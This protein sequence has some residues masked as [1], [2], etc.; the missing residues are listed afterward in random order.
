[1]ENEMRT[2]LLIPVGTLLALL[3]MGC[4]AG[5]GSG[6]QDLQPAASS[7]P[8][9]DLQHLPALSE[10]DA[11][12][13]AQRE[14]SVL[15]PGWFSFF[16]EDYTAGSNSAVN[17]AGVT[18]FSS[19]GGSAW[20]MYRIGGF[21]SDFSPTSLH[22]HID[23]GMSQPYYLLVA[24][25]RLGRW[26][27]TGPFTGDVNIELPGTETGESHPFDY[28]SP[29]G[30]FYCSVLVDGGASGDMKLE[31]LELGIHGGVGAPRPPRNLQVSTYSVPA[32][33]ETGSVPSW[34][35]SPDYDQ[36]D[37]A[38]YIVE[39]TDFFDSGYMEIG[40]AGPLET[41]IVI[42]GVRRTTGYRVAAHDVSGNRS[43]W[44]YT[45][46]DSSVI[47]LGD[48]IMQVRL[49][50]PRGPL[51]GPV[52]VSFD[53]S[54]SYSPDGTPIAEYKLTFDN[55]TL[56]YSGAD[57][58]VTRTLQPGCYLITATVSDSSGPGGVS[59]STRRKLIVYPRWEAA[60]I[61]V[62]EADT[63]L[64]LDRFMM[65]NGGIDPLSGEET[66]ISY[67]ATLPGIAIR[68][69]SSGS[70]TLVPLP[71]TD[72]V[73]SQF[74]DP[75]YFDGNVYFG[76]NY[77]A[78]PSH[79]VSVQQSEASHIRMSISDTWA[80]PIATDDSLFLISGNPA[81]LRIIDLLNPLI[82]V[83]LVPPP[84]SN[85]RYM[86]AAW[87]PASGLI[88]VAWADDAG[89]N[90]L[91]F[92]PV[93][94]IT[95]DSI[96]GISASEAGI[97]LEIDPS[98]GNACLLT[99]S[100]SLTSYLRRDDGV[101]S[102][103]V[104]VDNSIGNFW[105]AD[106]KYLD[107]VPYTI[108]A[109]GTGPVQ[110]YRL[111]TAG[112]SSVNTADYTSDGFYFGCLL[113]HPAGDSFI[114]HDRINNGNMV[115]TRLYLDDTEDPLDVDNAQ[116]AWGFWLDSAAGADGMYV[117]MTD[118]TNSALLNLY[119]ADGSVWSEIDSVTGVSYADLSATRTGEVFRSIRTGG[120]YDFSWW[121]GAAW[122]NRFVIPGTQDYFPMPAA[123]IGDTQTSWL[124]QDTTSNELV[125]ASG[126][127]A[128]FATF[129]TVLP[130]PTAIYKGVTSVASSGLFNAVFCLYAQPGLALSFGF[131]DPYSGDMEFLASFGDSL[132]TGDDQRAFAAPLTTGRTMEIMPFR[133]PL[134][135][136]NW[137]SEAC[138]SVNGYNHSAFR[139]TFIPGGELAAPPQIEALPLNIH[140]RYSS[141]LRR[142][143]SA[144]QA[145]G[146][147]AV[148]IMA[149]IHGRDAYMEWSNFGDWEELPL[150]AG[151]LYPADAELLVDAAGRWHLFWRD[152]DSGQVLCRRTL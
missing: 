46:D 136:S 107:G 51:E 53:M 127:S 12:A 72:T 8:S 131:V 30:R 123:S 35:F 88:E 89:L 145:Y 119:S 135:L 7:V 13:D 15:G 65:M 121:N 3:L 41:Q 2:R 19:G 94:L 9:P 84:L 34:Q 98:T 133:G 118:V 115:T 146:M 96:P 74:T 83:F 23:P 140:N 66:L 132:G 36:P 31:L 103:P 148:S 130:V 112:A 105:P 101:W 60:D 6:G 144:A 14:I 110:V 86:D 151:L 79:L 117:Q 43:N 68:R 126:S 77:F 45:D 71:E 32:S 87:N 120:G 106:L 28:I 50:M 40:R 5:N 38:G 81:S 70:Y 114:V 42:P 56:N 111:E 99:R 150:P 1:M 124:L 95:V 59:G 4:G 147:T 125:R 139:Y 85:F 80:Q 75:A 143:V 25:F 17:S 109:G 16:P 24:D 134:E 33:F 137:R 10:L 61:V 69:G 100:S 52:D 22:T 142:T 58:V 138:L 152:I 39:R 141:D 18:T 113:P 97:D 21:T 37:F 26:R 92:D 44:V 90:W 48:E 78:D 149:N 49:K 91:S 57:P 73:P 93:N 102:A 108:F 27:S 20:A 55:P 104:A 54:E 128:G 62:K 63:S 116:N 29:A 64:G 76:M 11:I 67:D 47:L 122:E 82:P 129:A